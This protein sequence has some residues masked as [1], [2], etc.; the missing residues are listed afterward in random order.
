MRDQMQ[1]GDLVLFYHSV[2]KSQAIMGT[3]K[4][5]RSAYPDHFAFDSAS[6]YYD[7]KSSPAAPRWLMVDIQYVED[8]DPPISLDE[9]K[10]TKAL[11]GMMLLQKGCRLSVQLVTAREWETISKLRH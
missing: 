7:L 3:A 9:L 10:Q 1:V 2:V 6:K 8:F 11:S 5:A 4:V